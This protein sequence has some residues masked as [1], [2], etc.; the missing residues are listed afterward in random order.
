MQG[1]R[2]AGPH[3][4]KSSWLP[5]IVLAL[6]MGTVLAVGAV[7]PRDPA[8]TTE[9]VAEIAGTIRCPTCNGES[10]AVSDAEISKEIRLDIA[11]RLQ[12]G[13]VPDQIRAFYGGR[14]GESI[15]LTPEASGLSGMVWILPVAA[16][17]FA[18]GALVMVLGRWT[19]RPLVHASDADKALVEQ[20]LRE[21]DAEGA[22]D[23]NADAGS[24]GRSART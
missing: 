3:G 15:L 21:V 5:W 11:Q 4:W 9:Q 24:R 20:A 8:T 1:A 6:V 2:V 18:L 7:A 13:E 17:V 12:K 22:T 23:R 14:Y 10:V 16:A 19:R